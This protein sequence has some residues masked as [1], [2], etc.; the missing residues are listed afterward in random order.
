MPGLGGIFIKSYRE[1]Y[2]P[3]PGQ[4][5]EASWE[6]FLRHSR[7]SVITI[8][9]VDNQRRVGYMRAKQLFDSKSR[10]FNQTVP[11][12]KPCAMTLTNETWVEVGFKDH[13][14]HRHDSGLT[15]VSGGPDLDA[16]GVLTA[17]AISGSGIW[18]S[19]CC[20]NKLVSAKDRRRNKR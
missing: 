7:G 6:G 19:S 1:K 5:V 4:G 2:R 8:S 17:G 16:P 13:I 12:P 9:V 18:M 3:V 14:R 10:P 15:G 20:R 11:S